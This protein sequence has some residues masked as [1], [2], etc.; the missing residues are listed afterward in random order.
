MTVN[1]LEYLRAEVPG[2]KRMSPEEN[3]QS[4]VAY[5]TRSVNYK[6]R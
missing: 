4:L 2:I 6:V 5:G 1:D 3:K